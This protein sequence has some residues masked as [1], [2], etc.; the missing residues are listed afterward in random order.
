MDVENNKTIDTYFSEIIYI[1][2]PL[3]DSP[4]YTYEDVK[5][6]NLPGVRYLSVDDYVLDFSKDDHIDHYLRTLST[7]IIDKDRTLILI[8]QSNC[9]YKVDNMLSR[10]I[11]DILGVHTAY[12]CDNNQSYLRAR[13]SFDYVILE[14]LNIL[15]TIV[16]NG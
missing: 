15:E 1:T 7:F 8:S 10:L 11:R 9:C 14:N 2:I 12:L 13:N 6:T 5:N 3:T 16:E 4:V